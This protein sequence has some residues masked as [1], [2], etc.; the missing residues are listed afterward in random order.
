[1]SS[2]KISTCKVITTCC[3]CNPLWR[4]G[5]PSTCCM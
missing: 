2:S 3:T 1:M 4:Y 5:I